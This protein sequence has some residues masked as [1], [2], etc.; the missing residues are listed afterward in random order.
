MGYLVIDVESTMYKHQPSPGEGGVYNVKDKVGSSTSIPQKLVLTGLKRDTGVDIIH[1]TNKDISLIQERIDESDILIGFNI[2]FDLLWLRRYGIV[3]EGKQ[4]WDCQLAE[5][6]LNNQSIVGSNSLTAAC[7]RHDLPTKTD[8]VREQYWEKGIDTDRVP[9]D[10]LKEYLHNDLD[11]T[12]RLYSKQKILLGE[13]PNLYKLFRIHCKDLLTLT[14]M[15]YNGMQF[16]TTQAKEEIVALDKELSKVNR[17]FSELINNKFISITSNKHLSALLYGGKLEETVKR[18]VG[19]YKTGKRKGEIKLGNS[20]VTHEFPRLVTPG[21]KQETRLSI[22]KREAGKE[23][24][25]TEWSVGEDDLKSIKGNKT[26]SDIIKC[27]LKYRELSKLMNTY[28]DG[29]C[30]MIDKKGWKKDTIHGSLNQC[31]TVTGRLSASAPNVQN[32]DKKTKKFLTS[33]LGKIVNVDVKALEIYVAAWLAKDDVLIQELLAN[34]DIHSNNMRDFGLED[35]LIAKTLVFRILYGGTEY[36]FVQDSNFTRVSKSKDYWKKAIEK[37]YDKYSGIAEWHESIVREVGDKGFII[38]PFGRV[39]KYDYINQAAIKNYIVQGSGADI[40]AISR[41]MLYN[42]LQKIKL[43]SLL[44][45]TVH[46]S[47]VMDCVE[48]EIPQVVQTVEE[49]FDSL[50]S[51]INSMYK[52][53]NFMLPIRVEI[54]SGYNQADLTLIKGV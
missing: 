38:N 39:Y 11:I 14:E 35:R 47:I 3:Y 30:K 9:L 31:V 54:E 6:M 46:D 44:I 36:G 53:A 20:I 37:F 12:E 18:V 42:R 21:K 19:V 24:E 8:I 43:N 13:N 16:D 48:E 1:H 50:P 28:L 25:A 10:I 51:T 41:A 2:Q 23:Q 17:L 52:E 32:A 34:E 49:V 26:V 7:D 45:N 22:N 27:I 15:L 5:W 33:R 4:V 29:W 40:V